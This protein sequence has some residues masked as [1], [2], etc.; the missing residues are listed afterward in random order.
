MILMQEIEFDI[1]VHITGI[2][3][4][5]SAKDADLIDAIFPDG[6]VGEIDEVS[7]WPRFPEEGFIHV[8]EE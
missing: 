5:E 1:Y 2:V 4:A 6:Y 7:T 8:L 3:E